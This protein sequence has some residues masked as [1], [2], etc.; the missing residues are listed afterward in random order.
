M[1]APYRNW[2]AVSDDYLAQKLA[3]RLAGHFLYHPLQ[4]RWYCADLPNW[5]R[6]DT[7]LLMWR[8]RECLRDLAEEITPRHRRAVWNPPVVP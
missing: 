5:R 7:L 3:E 8:V 2:L 6:D 4:R 1:S